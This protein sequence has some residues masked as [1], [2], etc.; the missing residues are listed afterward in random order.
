MVAR[1]FTEA[2]AKPRDTRIRGMLFRH[3]RSKLS[4]TAT[5]AL[6]RQQKALL[7]TSFEACGL[8]EAMMRATEQARARRSIERTPGAT[9]EHAA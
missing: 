4:C 3:P 2:A 1:G 6:T 5:T 7:L 8:D 9:G